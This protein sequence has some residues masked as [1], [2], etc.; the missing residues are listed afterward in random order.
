MSAV[1][2]MPASTKLKS[3]KMLLVGIKGK[4]TV[5]KASTVAER[6]TASHRPLFALLGGRRSHTFS[7]H[8][9]YW[10]ST[11]TLVLAALQ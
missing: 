11:F 9:F 10:C 2:E 6:G 5:V 3:G 7:S 4:G 8:R 1:V